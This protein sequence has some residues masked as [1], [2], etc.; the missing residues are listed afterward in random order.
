MQRNFP[1]LAILPSPKWAA[2]ELVRR[3]DTDAQAMAVSLIGMKQGWVAACLGISPAYLSQM[4]H[5]RT[6]PEWIVEP[7][8]TL[9]GT[10]LLA[11]VRKLREAQDIAAGLDSAANVIR[12]MAAELRATEA[13]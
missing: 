10:R 4:V 1:F 5:G 7:F 13:A 11:Q 12:R 3:V 2:P 8:C 6:V 9:T